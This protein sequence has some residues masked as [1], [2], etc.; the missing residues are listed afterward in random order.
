MNLFNQDTPAVFKFNPADLHD[1]AGTIF[2]R[3]EFTNASGSGDTRVA[4]SIV[5]DLKITDDFAYVREYNED[6]TIHRYVALTLVMYVLQN[7]HF[8]ISQGIARNFATV[9]EACEEFY[10][11]RGLEF[12]M[13]D[14][15]LTDAESYFAKPGDSKGVTCKVVDDNQGS[16]PTVAEMTDRLK[17]HIDDHGFFAHVQLKG[18]ISFQQE[19]DGHGGSRA[20]LEGLN[21]MMADYQL[22][23][24]NQEHFSTLNPE[25]L[26][27]ITG[28]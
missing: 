14:K 8:G 25:V 24:A 5:R 28:Q 3:V 23:R 13:S 15:L 9:I 7:P 4:W 10:T 12:K 20:K 18:E 11:L 22:V 26:G 21:A 19:L 1:A 17:K 2:S 27:W 16:L 6:G